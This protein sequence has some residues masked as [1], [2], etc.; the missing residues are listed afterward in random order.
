[1]TANTPY[2][3]DPIQTAI[4]VAYRNNMYIR[5]RYCRASRTAA[6]SSNI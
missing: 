4:T 2:P 1:M 6:K 3:V 5:T